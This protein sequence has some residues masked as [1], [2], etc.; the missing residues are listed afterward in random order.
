MIYKGINFRKTPHLLWRDGN[1]EIDK[2][3]YGNP[4]DFNDIVIVQKKH[5]PV[6][7][8]DDGTKYYD[9]KNAKKTIPLR[10]SL[11]NMGY[12]PEKKMNGEVY[13]PV[14]LV[15]KGIVYIGKIK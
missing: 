7:T 15:Y 1:K 2:D 9:V 14:Y 8:K 6:V 12:G 13:T 11:T 5:C 10:Y 3:F 4:V